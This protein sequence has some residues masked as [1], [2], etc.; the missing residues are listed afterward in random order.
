M[1]ISDW[2]S[3]VCSSDLAARLKRM[4]VKAGV[5][6]IMLLF[7]G[8]PFFIELKVAG[9]T[10]SPGQKQF[11]HLLVGPGLKY[12]ICRSRSEERRGGNECVSPCRSRWSPYH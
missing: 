12:A 8:R 3:D 6:D 9:R 7:G 10:P 2:S 4:G 1:R 11:N 5:A